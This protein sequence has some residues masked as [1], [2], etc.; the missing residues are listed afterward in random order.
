MRTV[1]FAFAA[2]VACS[3]L[4]AAVASRV[5]PCGEWELLKQCDSEWAD[6]PLGT[7]STNTI[8]SAG[9]AMTCVTM[10]LAKF[11]EKVDG[12]DPTPLSLDKWL[13]G[14]GGY[15]DSDLIVWNSVAKLGRLHMKEDVSS[16]TTDKIRSFVDRCHPVI[17]NVREGSHWV[18]ITGYDT[19]DKH[20]FYVN[21]PGFTDASYEYSGMSDFVVYTNATSTSTSTSTPTATATAT[22]AHQP[23]AA[24]RSK[25]LQA[26]LP[27]PT[28]GTPVPLSG[29]Y[30]VDVSQ[31]TSQSAFECM[32]TQHAVS[33]VIIRSYTELG[34]PDSAVVDTA[35]A[36]HAAGLDVSVYHFPDTSQSA[37]SQISADI[38]YLRDHGVS[39]SSVWVDVEHSD[40]GSDTSANANFVKE[41]LDA[42]K[43]H[44][45]GAGVYTSESQWGPIAGNSDIASGYP[46]WWAT[47]NYEPNFDGFKSFGGWSSPYMHQ[48]KGNQLLCGA[49]VDV[50]WRP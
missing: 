24:L 38:N 1:G 28:A 14:N 37:S 12:R 49:G 7:S 2:L 5:T 16:L 8:C 42:I 34:S 21:D 11:H 23:H 45:V 48:Y 6:H 43:S 25:A 15:V 13:T 41:C 26:P 44:G 27:F 35:K 18:L 46:L 36:A 33:F 31:P 17:A 29:L 47:Y 20:K 4:A 30:G 3:A 32:K 40:W 9:C 10:S 22:A 50:N 39:F 19:A